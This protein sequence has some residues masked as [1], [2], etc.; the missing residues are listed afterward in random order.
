VRAWAAALLTAISVAA[1][2]A[3]A[4]QAFP[5]LAAGRYEIRLDGLLCHTCGRMIVEE[6]S[7][8]PQVQKAQVDFERGMMTLTVR[9]G[10]TLKMGRLQ[11]ALKRASK[12]ADLDTQF[13][14]QAVDYKI[15]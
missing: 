8:L 1:P 2:A 4:K 10:Q 15:T 12:R 6:V 3:A 5:D 14:I 7:A 9:P 11:R 13:T